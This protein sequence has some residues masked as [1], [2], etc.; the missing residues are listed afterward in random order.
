VTEILRSDPPDEN[1]MAM[2]GIVAITLMVFILTGVTILWIVITDE[3]FF[4][5]P[6]EPIWGFQIYLSIPALFI[7]FI[8]IGMAVVVDLYRKHFVPDEML[9]KQRLEKVVPRRELR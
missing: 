5:A 2:V 9:A 3:P 8:F 1:V 7:G 4:P 6:P